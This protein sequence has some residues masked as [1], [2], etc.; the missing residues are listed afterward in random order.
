MILIFLP[1]ELNSY[2][3]KW[4][5]TFYNVGP[6]GHLNLGSQLGFWEEG[7]EILKI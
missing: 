6:K 2:A 5:S 1:K 7:Q 3:K 4:G